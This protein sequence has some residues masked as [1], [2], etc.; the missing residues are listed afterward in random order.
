MG[1]RLRLHTTRFSA[2]CVK[3]LQQA[4][5]ENFGVETRVRYVK[6]GGKKLPHIYIP[7]CSRDKFYEVIYPHVY[8]IRCMRYKLI[9]TKNIT[10]V[11][12]QKIAKK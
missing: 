10:N 2:V 9:K 3:R 4:L 8:P 5:R 12:T 11:K 1:Q 6:R 7:R